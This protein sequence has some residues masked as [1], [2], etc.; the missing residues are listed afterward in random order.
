[1]P[2]MLGFDVYGMMVDG[3]RKASAISGS[4]CLREIRV[5]FIQRGGSRR[6]PAGRDVLPTTPLT[7]IPSVG[8][9]RPVLTS[10]VVRSIFFA[11]GV[12]HRKTVGVGGA[13]GCTGGHYPSL[14]F[15]PSRL[16]GYCFSE[17]HFPSCAALSW[18]FCSVGQRVRCLV[19]FFIGHGYQPPK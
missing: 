1:M 10:S 16:A 6:M 12:L 18:R 17:R 2:L 4:I 3:E 8:Q 14:G 19:S 5:F 7:R 13:A 15:A 11:H 9:R